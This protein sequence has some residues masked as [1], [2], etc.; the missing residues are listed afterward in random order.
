MNIIRIM[1]FSFICLFLA[2]TY[3]SAVYATEENSE[4]QLPLCDIIIQLKPAVVYVVASFK[5][6]K[7]SQGT[8]FIVHEDGYLLTAA[9]IVDRAQS[10]LVGWPPGQFTPSTVSAE[11]IAINNDLDLA[12][13]NL[14]GSGF[15]DIR[16]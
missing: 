5:G 13:L 4:Q 14:E 12:L 3:S 1:L 8:G 6:E 9:H 2:L 16:N 10:I 7:F 11:I 15:P